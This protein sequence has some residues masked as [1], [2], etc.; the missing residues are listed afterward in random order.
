MSRR[1][2]AKGL[3]NR[4]DT[5]FQLVCFPM[6]LVSKC[7]TLLVRRWETAFNLVL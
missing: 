7:E 1:L 3:R 6:H 5:V 2:G 4:S